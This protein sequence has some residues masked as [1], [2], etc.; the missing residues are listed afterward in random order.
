MF[1]GHIQLSITNAN[2]IIATTTVITVDPTTTNSTDD[3]K[4]YQST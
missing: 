1:K 4:F 3:H 2:S